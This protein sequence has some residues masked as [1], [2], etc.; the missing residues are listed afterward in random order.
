MSSNVER[1]SF[2]TQEHNLFNGS[3]LDTARIFL[4]GWEL[5]YCLVLL[6][7]LASKS[8]SSR[9][10]FPRLAREIS[11]DWITTILREAGLIKSTTTVVAL[12][13][14][15]LKGGCHWKVYR[16][17][18]R[19]S[20]EKE[21]YTHKSLV[22]KILSWDKTFLE[23]VLIYIK[24]MLNWR[25]DL[26]I[27]YLDSYRCES[28]FYKTNQ[29]DNTGHDAFQVCGVKVPEVYY[30]LEDIFNNRFGMVI[31]DLSSLEDC[32]P[33][34]FNYEDSVAC[35]IRLAEF[36]AA[37]WGIKKNKKIACLD[38]AA[39]WPLNCEANKKTVLEDWVHVLNNFPGVQLE[40]KGFEKL[41]HKLKEKLKWIESEIKIMCGKDY[42]TLCHGD[43]KISNLFLGRK[44]KIKKIYRKYNKMEEEESDEEQQQQEDI[45]LTTSTDGILNVYAIDWQWFGYGNCCLDVVSFLCTSLLENTLTE[46]D[47]LLRVYHNSLI[48]YAT[49]QEKDYPW[50]LFL[51][52]FKVLFVDFCMFCVVA[53]WSK[54]TP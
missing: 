39:Y 15:N 49:F 44:R 11:Q 38:M 36:H 4:R 8:L 19:Y 13:T 2:L 50:D 5:L 16:V 9:A 45:T 42:R 28:L 40:Q 20:V 22:I 18:L 30:N 23:K 51:H 37:N 41:G 21:D 43:Y 14:E 48:K 29:K 10:P 24:F 26:D 54:M 32:Q 25:N 6:S 35:M 1:S 3:T 53:K 17:K 12:W 7:V 47:R 31:Q 27:T 52:H 46:V 33:Y 34:G